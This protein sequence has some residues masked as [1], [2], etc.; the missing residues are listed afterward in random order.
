MVNFKIPEKGQYIANGLEFNYLPGSRTLNVLASRMPVIV[1]PYTTVPSSVTYIAPRRMEFF[2]TPPQDIYPQ[3]WTDQLIIHEFRHAVQYSAINRGITKG[4]S[5]ILGEYGTL[6]IFGLFTPMW[7]VEGDATVTE[8]ALHYS[9]RGRTPSFEMKLRAQFVEKGIYSYEKAAFGSYR[10]FIPVKYEIG[11]QLVGW[12]R[13]YY[14]KDLWAAVLENIAKKPFTLTPFSSSIK[15]QTGL[16]KYQLY[17]TITQQM[18]GTWV[19]GDNLKESGSFIL[20][21]NEKKKTYTEYTLPLIF[22]DSLLIAMKSSPD[23]LTRAVSVDKNGV[24]HELFKAGVNY[25][26]E[27]LS[28]SD[29]EIYW[30][31]II[32]DPR[33]YLRDYRV[34][35]KYSFNTGKVSQLTHRT[36]YFAP[37]VSNNGRNL[38][39]VE[40]DSE[41][42]YSLLV[43]R[44][45]DGSIEKI[46]TTPDNLLFIH[47]S[48]SE[49]DSMIVSAVF[50]KRGNSIAITD[51]GSG[52]SEILLPFSFMEIKR[53]SFYRNY[54]IY[55]ASYNGKDNIYAFDRMTHDIFKITS[56]R[57]GDSDAFIS[58]KENAIIYS[59]YTSN[60]YNIAKM[61]LDTAEWERVSVPSRSP[62]TLAEKLTEQ[63]GFIYDADSVPD[64]IYHSRPYSKLLNKINIHSWAPIGID[65]Q[66]LTIAPGITLFS[67]NLLETPVISA[68]RIFQAFLQCIPYL[69]FTLTGALN[70]L[71]ILKG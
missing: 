42:R 41:N 16:N 2:L 59:D 33:W 12:S 14:G 43:L 15:R 17:D 69:F 52:K 57:F 6:G 19:K 45:S 9:G 64:I 48:W 7:F 53:P 38:A 29:S 32:V 4:L 20:M 35:K 1:H 22:R 68:G 70:I 31:E 18:T 46:Y 8:T 66:N 24:E 37:S 25:Y 34:I 50:G 54:I 36:R 60:G 3:D 26:S 13:I 30:S 39:V 28:A 21:N 40:A 56:A 58:R 62:F 61:E 44:I 71:H 47:P 27:S 5:R 63:E 55:T 23:F 67:Q 49:N 65:I 10:D 51:I 11:Y